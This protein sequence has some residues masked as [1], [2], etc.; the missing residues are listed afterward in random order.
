MK[1]VFVCSFN[2]SNFYTHFTPRLPR[3]VE[4]NIWMSLLFF[5]ILNTIS[6]TSHVTVA[7]PWMPPRRG[8]KCIHNLS[9]IAI[10]LLYIWVW[11]YGTAK[12]FW[13]PKRLD[14]TLCQVGSNIEPFVLLHVLV[15][16][17]CK[18]LF[19][20]L[21]LFIH[22]THLT[23]VSGIYVDICIAVPM[24]IKDTANFGFRWK[25]FDSLAFF[26]CLWMHK[27]GVRCHQ[28]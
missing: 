21:V 7:T 11:P 26:F 28:I 19:N 25:L 18:C 8:W 27:V 1:Y 10:S 20:F 16:Y 12:C 24:D 14:I 23:F 22:Y 5:Y 17:F 3:C 6:D 4:E 13:F 15:L 9:G 2:F